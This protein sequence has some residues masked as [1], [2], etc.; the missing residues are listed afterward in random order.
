MTDD[1]TNIGLS[2]RRVLGGLGAI[3]IASAGAGL[4]TT[5]YFSDQESFE[6]NSL[7]AGTLAVNVTQQITHV[8]Q[9]GIGPD[10]LAWADAGDGEAGVTT[11]P[12]VIEDAKPG[13]EYEFCWEVELEGNPGFA[14][15]AVGDVSE[16]TGAE[17]ET[18][19][20][21]DLYDVDTD[22]DMVTIGEAATA[23]ATLTLCPEEG[24]EVG[25]Q[26]EVFEGGLDDLLA[27]LSEGLVVPSS[28]AVEG[29]GAFCH[30]VECPVTLCIEIEI[31]TTVGNE[32]QGAES[33]FDLSVYAEQCR[34]N[35]V[36]QFGNTTVVA[37]DEPGPA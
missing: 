36:E 25:A 13:D 23:V 29:D 3:G 32:L 14:M 16:Q 11:D 20:A 28:E 27:A 4:G 24:E 17:V 34:H 19:S 22:A 21:D 10:E 33:S 30:D 15:V 35:D 2:R 9:D 37:P 6:G 1:N 26:V 18:V 8:D 5:A 12:I 7:T 31:P